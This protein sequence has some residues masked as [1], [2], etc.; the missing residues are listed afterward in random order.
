MGEGN[1]FQNT[2]NQFKPMKNLKNISIYLKIALAFFIIC[3]IIFGPFA[4]GVL[5]RLDPD[6]DPIL[7]IWALGMFCLTVAGTLIII[8]VAI[9]RGILKQLNW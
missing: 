8:T 7:L 4:T 9:F 3:A 2:K 5:L 6:K 1:L